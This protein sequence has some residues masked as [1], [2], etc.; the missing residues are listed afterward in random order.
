PYVIVATETLPDWK[1]V[2]HEQA[3]HCLQTPGRSRHLRSSRGSEGQ[4]DRN[5]PVRPHQEGSQ[6]RADRGR[7]ASPRRGSRAAG[8]QEQVTKTH[9]GPDLADGPTP[10]EVHKESTVSSPF[11]ET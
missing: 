4:A 9:E 6:R 7:P 2:R 8:D 10:R 5:D 1:G 3:S 11:A